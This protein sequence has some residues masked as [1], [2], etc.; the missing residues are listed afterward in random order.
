MDVMA[1]LST[2]MLTA[3]FVVL[4]KIALGVKKASSIKDFILGRESYKEKH[5]HIYSETV[6]GRFVIRGTRYTSIVNPKYTT[7]AIIATIYAT[8]IGADI[9]VGIAGKVHS[10]GMMYMCL[11]FL[12][13]YFWL[14]TSKVFSK[15]IKKF[16]G[17]YSL[18]DVMYRLYGRYGSIVADACSLLMGVGVLGVQCMAYANV[19]DELFGASRHWNTIVPMAVV[20]VYSLSGIR[21]VMLTDMIQFAFFFLVIFIAVIAGLYQAGG[22]SEVIDKLPSTHTAVHIDHSNV[23][24]FFSIILFRLIPVTYGPFIQRYLMVSGRKQ[25]RSVFK[26]IAVIDLIFM[27]LIYMIG[28]IVV[29]KAPEL[30]PTDVFSYFMHNCVPRVVKTMLVVGMF[31]IIMST[32]DSWLHTTA[33][34]VGYDIFGRD[35]LRKK[36][37]NERRQMNIIRGST[38]VIGSL[39]VLCALHITDIVKTIWM[40]CN[41]WDPLIL[42]PL[43]AGFM[44]FRTANITYGISVIG[45]I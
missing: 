41:I 36:Y 39:S 9:T 15:H 31:V 20:I 23:A 1:T 34:L 5:E 17:C 14:I 32:V 12:T 22:I 2:V 44:G 27:G 38:I 3:S 19:C 16:R 10:I 40:I 7:F 26:N 30:A 8:Y 37:R 21:A 4:L 43:C 33:V 35:F 11:I 6:D 18:G 28:L 24:L 45:G 42:V 29:V 13:P 25:L